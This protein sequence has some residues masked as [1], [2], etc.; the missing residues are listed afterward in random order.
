[1]E[2][3]LDRS[4]DD[5]YSRENTKDNRS[6]ILPQPDVASVCQSERDANYSADEANLETMYQFRHRHQGQVE[7]LAKWTL[8]KQRDILDETTRTG[9]KTRRIS[10]DLASKNIRKLFYTTMEGDMAKT[11]ASDV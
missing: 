1:M 5:Q 11:F 8:E 7:A 3:L 10:R 9:T 4:S 6:M 2:P